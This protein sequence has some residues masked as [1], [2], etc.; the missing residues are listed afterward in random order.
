MGK[1]KGALAAASLVSI[2]AMIA[3]IPDPTAKAAMVA[4]TFALKI[5]YAFLKEMLPDEAD[6]FLEEIFS[7][8]KLTKKI[9]RSQE[10]QQA[11]GNTLQNM[12]YAKDKS[13]R[14]II[15][16]AF[17]GAYISSNEY[18]KNNLERLQDVAS[19][20]SIPALQHLSF[21]KTAIIPIR[22]K[23]LEQELIKD[24]SLPGFTDVEH[25]IHKKRTTSLNGSYNEWFK[26][27]MVTYRT[28]LELIL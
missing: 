20:I 28:L 27:E 1:L 5:P 8:N 21:L 15:K 23:N 10:F 17:M 14:K 9:V 6:K 24:T 13:R 16:K 7:S 26:E 3:S 2:D 22:D 11:L 4:A 19:R 18:A 25:K 12:V